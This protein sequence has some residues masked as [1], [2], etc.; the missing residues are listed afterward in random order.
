MK[1][2]FIIIFIT[3]SPSNL[4]LRSFHN[5]VQFLISRC[6]KQRQR[7]NYANLIKFVALKSI[8]IHVR[9]A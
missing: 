7:Y 4:R 1:V 6:Q 2:R 8:G 3:C 5:Y 9:V